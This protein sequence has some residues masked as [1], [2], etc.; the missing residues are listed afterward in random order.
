MLKVFIGVGHGGKDPGAVKFVKESEANLNM[1]LGMKAELEKN[2][3]QVKLSREREEDDPLVEEI[4]EANA[5]SADAAVEVHNNAGGGKGFEVYV[6]T[7]H[8]EQKS[9]VLASSIEKRVIEHGQKS[10]GIKVKKNSSGTDYFGWLRQGLAPSVLCEGFFVDNKEDSGRYD[11]AE[12]QRDYGRVYALG[13]LDYLG[14][15]PVEESFPKVY[16][17]LQVGIFSDKNNAQNLKVKLTESGFPAF[18]AEEEA[19]ARVCVGKFI[20]NEE[21]KTVQE[22]L[23]ESGF[24]TFI[25]QMEE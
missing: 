3:V 10:R 25:R 1:A 6:Q 11:T 15:V 16:L 8:Q 23:A 2:G 21:A 24:A 18:I 12:K 4:R 9:R 14:I 19:G 5:F 20:Q 17:T 22:S 13:V 7:N